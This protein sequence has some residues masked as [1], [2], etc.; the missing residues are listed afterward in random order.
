MNITAPRIVIR[1][2]G[3]KIAPIDIHTPENYTEEIALKAFNTVNKFRDRY[4]HENDSGI[5]TISVKDDIVCVSGERV[6]NETISF[7][8]GLF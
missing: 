8:Q 6:S 4:S 5:I 1:I 3:K 2:D 7:L